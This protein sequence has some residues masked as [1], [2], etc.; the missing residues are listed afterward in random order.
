M[1]MSREEFEC[2]YAQRSGVSVEF[3]R[4]HGRF[5]VRC[6]CGDFGCSG[7]K[8]SKMNVTKEE[9]ETRL[10]AL[11]TERQRILDNANAFNGA[12]SECERILKL[13]DDPDM[14]DVAPLE[15]LFVGKAAE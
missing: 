12:I 4:E 8:I 6:D 10:S 13:L 14:D 9:I 11:R 3:L 5:A 1:S 15:P 2:D 7:W